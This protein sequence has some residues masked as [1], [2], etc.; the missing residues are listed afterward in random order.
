MTESP[1][2]LTE[3]N[4]YGAKWL[5]SQPIT[6]FGG[7]WSGFNTKRIQLDPG[8]YRIEYSLSTI[9]KRTSAIGVFLPQTKKLVEILNWQTNTAAEHPINI[10]GHK[11]IRLES[12]RDIAI[13]NYSGEV[14]P[15]HFSGAYII[16]VLKWVERLKPE[17]WQLRSNHQA[18]AEL[19]ETSG[20]SQMNQLTTQMKEM[21][22][23]DN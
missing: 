8:F 17:L 21:S 4:L 14:A 9:S 23:E 12:N 13:T 2:Y 5:I 16:N 6:L 20:L 10:S 3:I 11:Y 22:T 7:S 19:G 18:Q 15:E 1:K